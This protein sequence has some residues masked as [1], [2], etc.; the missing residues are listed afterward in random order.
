M[1]N[2]ENAQR[3]LRTNSAILF[4]IFGAIEASNYFPPQDFINEF[5]LAGSD[6]CDQDG[7]MSDWKP[8]ELNADEYLIVKDW[9]MALHPDAEVNSLGVT[10]WR[11]WVQKIIDE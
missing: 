1:T 6:P 2:I 4:G 11:D 8:F 10:C 7:R 5:F 9:W 3:I